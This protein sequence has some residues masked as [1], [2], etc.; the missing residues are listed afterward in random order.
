MCAAASPADGRVAGAIEAKIE[1][2]GQTIDL[3][4]TMG[5]YDAK[6]T[7]DVED[8]KFSMEN[9]GNHDHGDLPPLQRNDYE[10][11]KQSLRVRARSGPAGPRAGR[12]PWAH[13]LSALAGDAAADKRHP[14]TAHR[15]RGGHRTR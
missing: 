2:N 1:L 3:S 13:S 6:M 10:E 5:H 15:A 4:V 12:P 7:P 11:V 9:E 14:V 8:P